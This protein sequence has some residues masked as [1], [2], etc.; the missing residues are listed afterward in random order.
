MSHHSDTAGE[1]RK[2]RKQ[3]GK[4]DKRRPGDNKTFRKNFD[5]IDWRKPRGE[6][7]LDRAVGHGPGAAPEFA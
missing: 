1:Y 6:I 2:I 5:E 4:G 7:A 3:T